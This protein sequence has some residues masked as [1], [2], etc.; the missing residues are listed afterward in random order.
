MENKHRDPPFPIRNWRNELARIQRT[1]YDA[2]CHGA[3]SAGT[4]VAQA[5]TLNA[6]HG[7]DPCSEGYDGTNAVTLETG[8]VYAG[9]CKV[10]NIVGGTSGP[11]D[12]FFKTVPG[13]TQLQLSTYTGLYLFFEYVTEPA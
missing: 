11:W 10:A 7:D 8:W 13:N 4:C 3:V 1:I 2:W 6:G 12:I 5:T 9:R